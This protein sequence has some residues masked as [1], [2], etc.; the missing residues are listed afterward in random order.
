VH[1]IVWRYRV[2]EASTSAFEEAY[3]PDG[4]WVELFRQSPG[5]VGTE[6]VRGEEAG[7]YL[8]I[9][10]WSSSAAYEAF[11]RGAHAEYERLDAELASLTESEELVARGAAVD[12]E[13]PS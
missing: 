13:R 9:D 6:L 10:R 11:L 12:G 4:A 8:T 2:A 7:V 1:V 3:R 5:F